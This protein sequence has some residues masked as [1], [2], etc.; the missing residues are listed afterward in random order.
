MRGV[1][2]VVVAFRVV[3]DDDVEWWYVVVERAPGEL[4]ADVCC[5]FPCFGRGIKG[6]EDVD[7]PRTVGREVE[8]RYSWISGASSEVC[9]RW[10]V[11]CRRFFD[12]RRC[13][14]GWRPNSLGHGSDDVGGRCEVRADARLVRWWLEAP[15]LCGV[16]PP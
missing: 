14:L 8:V 7:G 10:I 16:V 4:H 12:D 2:V 11:A 5:C 15:F 6:H 1:E 13:P 9:E 3:G